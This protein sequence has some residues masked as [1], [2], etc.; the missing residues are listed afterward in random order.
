M[1]VRLIR[2]FCSPPVQPVVRATSK[3][4][5]CDDANGIRLD[6]IDD[7]KGEAVDQAATGILGH[8]RPCLRV[9]DNAVNC[10]G[11]SF[12]VLGSNFGENLL[13]GNELYLAFLNL[14]H[15]TFRFFCPK[16]INFLIDWQIEAR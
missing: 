8:Q 6:L 4:C 16:A 15:A 10:N 14:G 1:T 13:T 7:A 11:I 2:W 5:N 3:I 12:P 9:L